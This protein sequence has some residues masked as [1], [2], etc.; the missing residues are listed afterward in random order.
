MSETRGSVAGERNAAS[1]AG[2]ARQNL[3]EAIRYVPETETVGRT[4]SRPY[5]DELLAAGPV[6]ESLLHSV[7]NSQALEG[8]QVPYELAARLLDEVLEEPLPDIG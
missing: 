7:I 1:P 5:I 2:K 6:R 4:A 3:I 8:V